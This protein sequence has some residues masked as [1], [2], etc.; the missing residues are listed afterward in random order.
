[1]NLYH[2]VSNSTIRLQCIGNAVVAAASEKA[3]RRQLSMA[4]AAEGAD[5][6]LNERKSNCC[7]IGTAVRGV[8]A[9]VITVDINN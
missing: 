1:M 3:A 9:G 7:Q 6:W 4:A 5:F 8:R 2:L